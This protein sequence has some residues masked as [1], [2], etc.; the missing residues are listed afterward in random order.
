MENSK[1]PENSKYPSKCGWNI[2]LEFG[3]TAVIYMH[4]Q[5]PPD[6]FL[7]SSC[8]RFP[9]LVLYLFVID[10]NSMGYKKLLKYSSIKKGLGNS[11]TER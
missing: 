3:N 9:L 10:R 1:H 8:L 7:A 6:F 5:L 11:F 4:Y 2:C